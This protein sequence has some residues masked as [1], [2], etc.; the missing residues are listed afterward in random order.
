MLPHH[1][2]ASTPD[3]PPRL[4]S[5]HKV[6]R[7]ELKRCQYGSTPRLRLARECDWEIVKVAALPQGV[8]IGASVCARTEDL[9]R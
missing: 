7:L 2:S 3:H 1:P 8:D 6:Q 5:D 9:R 4:H